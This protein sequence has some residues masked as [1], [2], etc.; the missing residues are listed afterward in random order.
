[1]DDECIDFLLSFKEVVKNFEWI[2]GGIWI[3]LVFKFVYDCFIK[4]SWC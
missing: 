4:E 1:M 3:F 2:V